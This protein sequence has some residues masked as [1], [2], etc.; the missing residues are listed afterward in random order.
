M[1]NSDTDYLYQKY[2]Y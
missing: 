2:K 1:A